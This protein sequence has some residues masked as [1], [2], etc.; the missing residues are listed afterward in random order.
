M[1]KII[2][3][4]GFT[5]LA[6]RI[7]PA[8][9]KKLYDPNKH[10][11]LNKFLDYTICMITGEIIYS[12]AFAESID[13]PLNSFKFFVLVV[14]TLSITVIIMLHSANLL[15]SFFSALL[16]YIIAYSFM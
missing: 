10:P 11:K 4:A 7:A 1:W 8:L 6:L 15:K 16:F 12:I 14:T 2:L 3:I 5:T 13:N 9:M